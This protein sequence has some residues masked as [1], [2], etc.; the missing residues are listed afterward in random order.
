M[1]YIATFHITARTTIIATVGFESLYEEG[2]TK[3]EIFDELD[4]YLDQDTKDEFMEHFSSINDL[5]EPQDTV[6]SEY[7][8]NMGVE[9]GAVV[10]EI[11]SWFST[12]E[13]NEFVEHYNQMYF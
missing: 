6:L 10:D 9:K 8:D 13:V 12:G 1:I 7:C 11:E 5:P 3:E 2:V 4:A